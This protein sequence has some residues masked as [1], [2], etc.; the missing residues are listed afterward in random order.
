MSFSVQA[1]VCALMVISTVMARKIAPI[2]QMKL[3][4]VSY[5]PFVQRLIKKNVD[6]NRSFN[7][8][9]KETVKK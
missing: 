8:I 2:L 4:V 5:D 6:D 3:D 9:V 7:F 1:V